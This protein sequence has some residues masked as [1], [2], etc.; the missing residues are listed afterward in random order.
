MFMVHPHVHILGSIMTQVPP[1]LQLTYLNIFVPFF[2]ETFD[3]LLFLF[4]DY[5]SVEEILTS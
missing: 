5:S 2:L 4:N 1:P 3:P